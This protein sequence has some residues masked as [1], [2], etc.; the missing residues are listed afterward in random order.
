MLRIRDMGIHMGV[1]CVR[2]DVGSQVSRHPGWYEERD[3]TRNSREF[4]I[5]QYVD[6]GTCLSVH[7][8]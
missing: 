7:R 6:I 4:G 2:A 1:L 3:W 8:G 5:L